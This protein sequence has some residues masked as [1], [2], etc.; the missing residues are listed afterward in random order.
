MIYLAAEFWF[1]ILA[2]L[3][4]FADIAEGPL[5][6][7]STNSSSSHHDQVNLEKISDSPPSFLDMQVLT[8]TKNVKNLEVKLE[9]ARATLQVKEAQVSEL[10]AAVSQCK[11]PKEEMGS[12]EGEPELEGLF[13][14]KIEAEIEYLAMTSMVQKLRVK[15]QQSLAD[16]QSR[17]ISK[18]GKVEAKA[19]VLK[20]QAEEAG[21]L[22][23]R[24]VRGVDE[25]LRF[26]SRTCKASFYLTL[27]LLS[28]LVVCWLF[29][30]RLSPE[31]AF[32][33]P[34]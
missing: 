1:A 3:Q 29:V 34:T 5:S 31:S 28:L 2:E 21:N 6:P 4:K 33:V 11:L 9:K 13:R 23:S 25:V 15:E 26:H 20:K 7:P 16:A 12:K 10:E 19:A 14:Q 30:F 24:D 18:L 32:S 22:V 17:M 27:Q 8:L